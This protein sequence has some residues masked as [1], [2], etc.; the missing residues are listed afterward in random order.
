MKPG[1]RQ[2]RIAAIIGQRGQMSVEELAELFTVSPETVRR[3]L[4][5]LAEQGAVQKVHG[6][7]K[8]PRPR[9]EASFHERMGENAAGKRAI[10]EKLAREVEPGDTLFIDT[11]STTLICAEVLAGIDG[12]TV[13]TNSLGIAEVMGQRAAV[14]LAGGRYGADN[15]QT[16]GPTALA[17]I[18]SYQADT[19]VLTVGALDA[20]AGAM[21]YEAGEA[22]VAR[23]MAANARRVIVVADASKFGRRAPFRVCRL[24]Q[25]DMLVADAAPEAALA[26]ALD[27]AGVTVR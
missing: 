26:A 9:P 18:D 12:L 2:A 20:E 16:L 10:A 11:G 8:A 14:Y 15:R 4:N 3:D 19:A 17:Q 21:D 25:I 1:V 27:A 24:A 7:A 22:E 5:G 6:G 13:I 23:A